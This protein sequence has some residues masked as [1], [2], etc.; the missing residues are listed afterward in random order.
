MDLSS[1][2]PINAKLGSRAMLVRLAFHELGNERVDMQ[3]RKRLAASLDVEEKHLQVHKRLLPTSAWESIHAAR[4]QIRRYHKR[5]TVMWDIGTALLPSAKFFEYNTTMKVLVNNLQNT[6]N[7]L[8]ERLGDLK[9]VQRTV[10]K[11]LFHEED[12]PTAE[13]FRTRFSVNLV[14]LPV[15]DAGDF[16]VDVFGDQI[17]V[18]RES[19][20]GMVTDRINESTRRC[21]ERL[22]EELIALYDILND[23]NAMLRSSVL[24]KLRHTCEM[25]PLLNVL[26]VQTLN[27]QAKRANSVLEN[28]SLDDIRNDE[29]IRARCA[30]VL[31]ELISEMQSDGLQDRPA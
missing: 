3:A 14:Y 11:S 29:W 2:T 21:S 22:L 6:V 13:A 27:T 31:R 28:H 4:H 26:D 12:W 15:P 24:E 9:H 1:P 10:Q 7:D 5:M 25:I 17:E 8:S 23:R 19:L 30:S 20:E 16:R 18:V